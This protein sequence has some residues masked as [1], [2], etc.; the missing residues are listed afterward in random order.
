MQAYLKSAMPCLGVYSAAMREVAREASAAYPLAVR[1]DWRDTM[2]ALWHEATYREERHLAITLARARQYR[3]FRTS[4]M[5]PTWEELIVDGAWWDLVDPI[6]THL[7]GEVLLQETDVVAP[8]LRAWATDANMWKRRTSI[9][10][11][12]LA[13]ER[14]DL[15]LLWACI[16]PNREDREFF[17]RKAIGWALREL[18]KTD[19]EAVLGYLDAHELSPLS[20][21]EALK[22]LQHHSLV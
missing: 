1:D 3:D 10:A 11:Q 22:W 15:E 4:A 7:V 12:L 21:R 14:T 9:I 13:R 18:S 6:A 8:V 20:R 17:V 2:L 16:E 19:R 5:L